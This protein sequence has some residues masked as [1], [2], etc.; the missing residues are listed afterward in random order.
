MR[1]E[2]DADECQTGRAERE[3][4]KANLDQSLKERTEA[5][6]RYE[7]RKDERDSGLAKYF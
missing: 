6:E 1:P 7:S 4:R 3:A 5:Q 2:E